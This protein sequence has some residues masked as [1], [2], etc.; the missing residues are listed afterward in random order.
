MKYYWFD[1]CRSRV[2]SYTYSKVNRACVYFY[3][4]YKLF[5]RSRGYKKHAHNRYTADKYML[6]PTVFVYS[7]FIFFFTLPLGATFSNYM[8]GCWPTVYFHFLFFLFFQNLAPF[9]SHSFDKFQAKMDTNQ[10]QE[11][12]DN[13]ETWNMDYSNK[14]ESV[15][16]LILNAWVAFFYS[17][18]NT[19]H[20]DNKVKTSPRH[21]KHYIL[22]PFFVSKGKTK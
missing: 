4:K 18:Y 20:V 17:P 8:I 1:F 6:R 10:Q 21:R 12:R 2:L 19:N 16:L 15:E 5:K 9:F 13:H 3:W 7:V 11:Q 22:S 14:K